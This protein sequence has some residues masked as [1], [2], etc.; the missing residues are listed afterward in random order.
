MSSK[1]SGFYR[2][3]HL[4]FLR[5]TWVLRIGIWWRH[6]IYDWAWKGISVYIVQ[7]WFFIFVLICCKKNLLCWWL[8]KNWVY[9]NVLRRHFM[10]TF[11]WQSS[12]ILFFSRTLASLISNSWLLY[13]RLGSISLIGAYIQ[14][15]MRLLLHTLCAIIALQTFPWTL[16]HRGKGS[17]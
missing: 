17:R 1:L 16:L 14:S 10:A 2:S 8:S 12:S 7:L 11:L 4:L 15:H 5:D 13:Q 9:Q 6:H 3:F